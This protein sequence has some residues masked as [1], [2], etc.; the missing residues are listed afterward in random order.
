M[1]DDRLLGAKRPLS[2]RLQIRLDQIQA[3]RSLAGR[4]LGG[5]TLPDDP[6]LVPI[7]IVLRGALS[8]RAP[9]ALAS[10]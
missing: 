5:L 8:G 10:G 9:G 2:S 1:T 6:I 4:L 7:D 3:A